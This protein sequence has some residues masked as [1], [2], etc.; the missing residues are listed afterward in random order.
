MSDC[1]VFTICSNGKTAQNCNYFRVQLRAS[2][3]QSSCGYK[4][5][6]L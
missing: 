1:V 2:F 4:E 5:V 6:K 3:V